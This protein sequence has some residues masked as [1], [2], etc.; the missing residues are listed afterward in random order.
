MKDESCAMWLFVLRLFLNVV[1]PSSADLFRFERHLKQRFGL[2]QSGT[3][4]QWCFVFF[5]LENKKTKY[6][7][8]NVPR[9]RRL[10]GT[11]SAARQPPKHK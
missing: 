1:I 10:V 6:K 3:P 4:D 5:A 7:R 8:R 11:T 9:C 2:R